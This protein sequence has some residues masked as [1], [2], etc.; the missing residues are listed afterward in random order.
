MTQELK[1]MSGH[2][3]ADLRMNRTSGNIYAVPKGKMIGELEGIFDDLK[4]E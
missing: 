4:K 1:A 2:S 3:R